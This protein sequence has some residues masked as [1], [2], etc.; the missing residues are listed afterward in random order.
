MADIKT[1]IYFRQL[2][3]RC[4]ALSKDCLERRTKEELR[5][6]AE[7]LATEADAVQQEQSVYA[8]SGHSR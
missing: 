4:L 1:A 5:K 2:A 7:E 8:E 3:A 6:L